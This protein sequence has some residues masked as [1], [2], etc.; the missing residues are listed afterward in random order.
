LRLDIT[1]EVAAERL[2]RRLA[3]FDDVTDGDQQLLQ[4]KYS[5]NFMREVRAV[6]L[7]VR[8]DS[9]T[10]NGANLKTLKDTIVE[11]ETKSY[12]EGTLIEHFRLLPRPSFTDSFSCPDLSPHVY[13]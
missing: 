1:I 6:C 13:S 7:F 12:A 10:T 11:I 8:A 2:K 5:P 4:S 3:A 9:L